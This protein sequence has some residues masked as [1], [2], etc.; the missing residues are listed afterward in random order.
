MISLEFD[1]QTF[2]QKMNVHPFNSRGCTLF[3]EGSFENGE[4][5]DGRSCGCSVRR[6]LLE[7]PAIENRSIYNNIQLLIVTVQPGIRPAPKC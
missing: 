3:M 6:L 4:L 5:G 2:P 1:F 7:H